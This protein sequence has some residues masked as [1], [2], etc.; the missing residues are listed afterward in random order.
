MKAFA[1]PG[2]SRDRAW[3]WYLAVT[4]LLSALY[5]F[6]PGLSGNG[7]L[8]NFLGLTGVLAIVAGIRMHKPAARA[9]W[10]LFAAGQF[11]FLS[12]DLYTYSYPK[13]LGADVGF[14]SIGD[15]L[16]LLVYPVLMAGLF[17]LVRR[18]SPRPD[19]AALIDA[20]I[21]TIGIGL[22]S[23]VFLIAPNVHLENLSLLANAVSVAYPLGDVLLLAAAIR[24]AVDAGKRSPAFWLLVSSIVCL[25]A[26][27]SAYNLALLKDT[28]NHQLI[29]DAGWIFYYLLW[30]AAALHPSMRSL[31]EPAVDSRTPLTPL[32]LTLLG[33]AC[34]I[35][36]GIRLAQSFGN[37]DV[38]VLIV[39]SAVLFL[40]VVVRM[41]GLVRQE[42]RV[43]SRERALRGAGVELVAA[44]GHDQVATAAISA[45]HRL[46]GAEPPVRLVLIAQ[47]QAVV[48]ASS[49][50]AT[51][52]LVGD[53]TRDWLSNGSGSL[54][55]LH[56]DPPAYVRGDLR[57]PEGQTTMVAPL[58][59]R[60]DVRGALVVSSPESVTRDL[61]EALG[62]LATQVSLAVE[63]ASLAADLHRRQGE[64]RFRSLVA[65]ASDLITVLDGEGL[66]TYQ[67]PSIERVLG[68]RS[69]EV[70][71]RRF[72]RL[73]VESDRPLLAQLIALDGPGEAEGHTIEC[74]VLHRDGTPLT[75]E[76]QHT[77]LL[78]DEHVHG[79][80]L[81]SRDV[82]ER[83]A[84]EEQLAHQAFHDPVT[85]L[86]NRALFSDRVEHALMRSTRGIPE[87]AVMFIDLDDFK[88][89]NDSLGHTAGDEVLQEV[90]RRLKIAVRPTDTVARFGGDEFA[91]LLDGVDGSSE[92][93]DAA[94]RILRALE[95][96]IEIDGKNV[97][98]RASVGICL[99]GE[100]LETPEAT[101]LLR[102]AD[103]AMY[104]AKR[105]SKGS[106]RVFE[107]TMHERVVE[108]LELRS[109]LQHALSLDQ[110]ELH[111]QPV[112]RLS[113]REILGVE[114]LVRWNH[115]TRGTIP[116]IQFIP[117]AEETGLIIPMGRWI[118][119]TACY[120]GVRLQERFTRDEPLT[121]SVNL[122]VRQL[123]SETL[124]ADVRSALSLTGLPASSL[125]LEITESLMLT[126]TDFAMQQLHD[127][128]GLGIRLAM[129]DFGTGYSSLS[130]L[131]RFP[132]DI[133]KMDRSFVG[134]EDNEA[135]TS[136]IIALGTS[137]SLEVVAEGI[138][139]AEQANSLEEL[140]CELGQG[141]LFAR[142]MDAAALSN[143]LA[144]AGE[145]A[146]EDIES[147]SASN[148]A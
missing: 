126:D 141:Y 96:P 136:A 73:L 116:P 28:Y 61:V 14:P 131:S 79:I 50:G 130:Y 38:L 97:V 39:A 128:K 11:L 41:A 77:D 27:D 57:L 69:H 139:L 60:G 98:P 117:V 59:V 25:M 54:R 135:L 58:T 94:S 9:A 16:Y 13:L 4:G 20:L 133:L 6:A 42:A 105:D 36:P 148:A 145:P 65:H 22:L 49:D 30:G 140:G 37:P 124:V 76:V 78:H 21:L 138:E 15:A 48:E 29:Y 62:A 1:L 84:F 34:L 35:A 103:V 90:G 56:S 2:W 8:I 12:G 80:V 142:P 119:E 127:L 143:F 51:G 102:N 82:S 123:Q 92:A 63:G 26:T 44:A 7:P 52:G 137:L 46:L 24:L 47:N 144:L 85:K 53:G 121:M 100:D 109:D 40:L 110:L 5:L 23:W 64:A 81:N 113:G 93:A 19:R 111:Y 101:E 122:S 83:K 3:I 108:R 129:D 66:V 70:E 31:E 115:P 17:I 99:V 71:G 112:V 104:M 32:R 114:A 125:V 86:A 68:Y 106:Y 147:P 10:W 75:F 118:L 95:L 134:S 89:V 132:V 146:E 45:V 74:S 91:V 107:P 33:A 120:E 72:D 67:S 55:V 88:T 87:I 18:R 43:V